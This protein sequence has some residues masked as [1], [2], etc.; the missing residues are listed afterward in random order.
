MSQIYLSRIPRFIWRV[1]MTLAL[2]FTLLTPSPAEANRGKKVRSQHITNGYARK[3]ASRAAAKFNPKA[4][5]TNGFTFITLQ[6]GKQGEK[7]FIATPPPP[8][9]AKRS[10]W[11][12]DHMVKGTYVEGTVNMRKQS[13]APKGDKRAKIRPNGTILGSVPVQR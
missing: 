11:V 8:K 12:I 1:T 7:V 3:V 4:G 13:N 5:L 6:K 10:S 9:G 2:A